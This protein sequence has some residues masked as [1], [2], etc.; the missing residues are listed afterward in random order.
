MIYL[1]FFA[2]FGRMNFRI[3]HRKS[4]NVNLKI[5]I[6]KITLKSKLI[7]AFAVLIGITIVIFHKGNKSLQKM[8]NRII[9]L[10]ESTAE[11]MLL[12]SRI[13]ENM[14]EIALNEKELVLAKNQDETMRHKEII[15]ETRKSL[16]DNKNKLME[17]ADD[18]GA[19]DLKQFEIVWN[20]YASFLDQVINLKLSG[21]KAGS[22][23]E[24]EQLQKILEET[25]TN[26]EPLLEKSSD[27]LEDIIS[28]NE[29]TLH[30]DR[31]ESAKEFR[32]ERTIGFGLLII[33]FI[34]GALIAIWIISSITKGLNVTKKALIR[35]AEGDFS[36]KID[37]VGKD[38]IGSM[39][40]QLQDM[41]DHLSKS[42]QIANIVAEGKISEAMELTKN[43]HNGDLD[44]A[45]KQM[46][47][48]LSESI[49]IADRVA[50]GD[51]TVKIDKS[52]DLDIA[53]KEMVEKL[54]NTV[55]SIIYSAE[56][57]SGGADEI[58]SGSQNVSQ[59]ASEQASAIEEISSAMEEMVSNINQNAENSGQT[60][61]I[62]KVAVEK[63]KT[64]NDASTKSLEMVKKIV[65]KIEIINEIA[66]RTD[67]L[68]INAAIEAARAGQH[69]KGFAVVASEVR[70]LSENTQKAA[71]DIT[72]LSSATVD[73][74][75]NSVK[76]L[77]EAIPEIVKTAQLV[78]EISASSTEQLSGANQINTAI[79]QLNQ[80]TQGNA[81]AA[82]ELASSADMFMVQSEKLRKG[83]SFFKH[84]NGH[85]DILTDQ[86]STRFYEKNHHQNNYQG[87]NFDHLKSSVNKIKDHKSSNNTVEKIETSATKHNVGGN[88]ES[89]KKNKA[90]VS[91][92]NELDDE[93]ERLE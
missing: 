87:G 28:A 22:A 1:I 78:Q 38:E 80:V 33:A 54:S 49:A 83:V 15:D 81:S 82:E 20:D 62:S 67:L 50:K 13:H 37:R 5:A 76:L 93:F 89:E 73:G 17:L 58:N 11:Q 52:G 90:S 51:L 3:Q 86:E 41:V 39:L 7:L 53:L 45:L 61:K 70:S 60:E 44:E 71:K 63:M 27:S 88:G 59:G 55:T 23:G 64:V 30:S 26:G 21:N 65:E 74:A 19:K 31:E 36:V 16:I 40:Q 66:N 6:M 18:A 84:N 69:G 9:Q 75:N 43:I 12:S 77:D 8:N 48:N 72:E 24:N 25:E 2:P 85:D 56:N 92:H 4:I 68:A 10:S 29:N 35:I 91:L 79:L 57:I 42:V 32:S 14:L 46:V 34:I 47:A